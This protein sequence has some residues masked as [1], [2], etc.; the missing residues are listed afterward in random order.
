MR[1][2]SG[3]SIFGIVL[4]LS[5]LQFSTSSCTK[6][7]ERDTVIQIERDTIVKIDTLQ[8][9]SIDTVFAMEVS[10]WDCFSYQNG[11]Y[12]IPGPKTYFKTAEGIEFITQGANVGTRLQTKKEVG[13][14]N[15]NIYYKW[16]PK[17]DGQFSNFVP[18]IK[19]DPVTGDGTPPIQ[20]VDLHS[21]TTEFVWAG[22]TLV[23]NNNWYYTRVS[24]IKGTDN[25]RFVTS[26]SNYDNKGGT[27]IFEKTIPIYTK[28]GYIAIRMG[29]PYSIFASCV[30]GE[31]KIAAN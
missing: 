15:K 29:D 16:K 22:S 30:L 28:H 19:Y 14:E 21:F 9:K 5:S 12:L 25:F 1:N 27:V 10:T 31:C 3:L 6:E 18:Q 24:H 11:G 7:V 23:S 17:A 20:S 4:L 13:F 26:M 8:V 2:F